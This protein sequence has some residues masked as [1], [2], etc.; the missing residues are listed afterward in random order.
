M[1]SFKDVECNI[2]EIASEYDRVM[3]LLEYEEVLLDKKL[4]LRLSKQKTLFEP[5][6]LEYKNYEKLC[7]SVREI[8]SMLRDLSGDDR[9]DF[10]KENVSIEKKIK[11]SENTLV[12]LHLSLN[13]KMQ[14]LVL[15][16]VALKGDLSGVLLSDLITGYT[17]FAEDN[18]LSVQYDKDNNRLC[19][20]GLNAKEFFVSEM[21][22][23]EARNAQKTGACQVYVFDAP[24]DALD[25]RLDDVEIVCYRSSGAGGQHINT[26]DSAIKATHIPT[27]LYTFCQEERSQ[28]QN[29]EK[30]L[31]R[32]K[33]KVEDFYN[34]QIKSSIDTQR[35]EQLKKFKAMPINKVYDYVSGSILDSAGRE[36]S[37]KDFLRGRTL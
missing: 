22:I 19:I 5:L 7:N 13:A 30:A 18:S 20:D 17:L 12:K 3:E 4:F 2:K 15:E 8:D 16:I 28:I 32:L 23:H 37:I 35:K 36:I 9:L 21:G 11:S 24:I 31:E 14:K 34:K 29:K 25:F 26:T 10:E 33:V 6:A 1:R 27:G